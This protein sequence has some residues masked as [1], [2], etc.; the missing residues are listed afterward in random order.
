LS[1]RCAG[2]AG[3]GDKHPFARARGGK[4]GKYHGDGARIR[5][6]EVIEWHLNGYTGERAAVKTRYASKIIQDLLSISF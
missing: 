3:G 2:S 4:H 6:V 1:A 5:G